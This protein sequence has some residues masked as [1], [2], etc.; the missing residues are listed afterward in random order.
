M[1]SG[2]RGIFLLLFAL[3][4]FSGLIYESIWT[5]YLKLFLGHAAYAQTLVLAIF[6]GGMAIGSALS[7]RY[8]VRWKNLLLCYAI[9]EGLIGVCALAFHIA[10]NLTTDFSY[11]TVIP[12]LNNPAVVNAFK[13]TIS[14][15]MILPQSVLLG[16]T[17]P[18]MSAGI[19]R[20]FPDKPGSTVAMLYFTNSIGAATGVLASG[21]VLIRLVGLPGTIGIAGLINIALAVTVWQLLKKPVTPGKTAGSKAVS[22]AEGTGHKRS[23]A[24]TKTQPAV[25]GCSGNEQTPELRVAIEKSSP[26]AGQIH[27]SPSWYRFFLLASLV[28][29][30]ASFIYEIGWIRMLSLVLGSSTHS[31]ELM[32]SAFILGL[33][34]GGLWI[35]WRIER[36]ASPVRYLAHVQ[37]CMGLLALLT[38]PLYGTTFT[39]MQWLV[40]TLDKTDTGYALFNLSSS[41]IAMTVML[42]ATFCAGMTLP[43]ITFI[44]IRGGHGERSIGAVYA[45]NTIGAII[46]VFFAIHLGMPF[47]GLNN[48]I[49]CGAGLDIA[50]G[51][52]L[53]WFAL[54]EYGS[55]RIPVIATVTGC[56]AVAATLLFVRLDPYKMGSG[57]YRAGEIMTPATAEVLYHMDGKTATVTCFRGNDA[58]V[59]IRTNGKS[60]AAIMTAQGSEASP[61][62]ST[63]TLLAVIPMSLNPRATTA[64]AIGLGSGLTSHTLLSNP[65]LQQVD[66]VEIEKGMIEGANNFRPRVESVFSDP[67]SK[68]RIDDAKTFFSTYNK[69]YDLIVSEPSNPWVSGVAGLFSAEFY[70]LIRRHMNDD[71]LFV[72]WIQLYEINVDLVVSVLKSISANFSDYA[73]Y[74]SNNSDIMVIARKNGRLPAPD[75]GVLKIPAIADALKRIHVE[76]VEDIEIRRIGNKHSFSRLL[77]TFPI[78][79]NSDYYPVLDQ[80]AAR[81]RFLGS[82]AQELL[83]FNYTMGMLESTEQQKATT[84]ITPSP[85]LTISQQTF[86]AMGLRD[87][88]LHG[89]SNGRFVPVDLQRKAELLK[90]MCAGNATG[91]GNERLELQFSLSNAMSLFLTSSEME[92]VW[93]T[94]ATGPCNAPASPQEREWFKLFKAVGTRD[95]GAMLEGAKSLLADGSYR[96]SDLKKYLLWVGMLGALSQGKR[97]DSSRLWSEY[98]V[99]LF[100]GSN[101]PTLM[102]RM[103]AAESR[104]PDP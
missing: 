66:T 21:F 33:A 69:K 17:F 95:A 73:V 74:A 85:D 20:L 65:R 51:V 27:A 12:H 101:E 53:C 77:E 103:L 22:T 54:G 57:V 92:A 63:M 37:V 19:L 81:A 50:L 38:L 24:K 60:D 41:A 100:N 45:A 15:L 29:G 46:G 97:E 96:S 58:S 7:S 70:R 99:K 84:N 55:R 94:L 31:F 49:A 2:L 59:S 4:G 32:L 71:A 9:T 14:A 61:D 78:Q 89:S 93:K 79:E 42:P 40:K 23:K 10:F 36:V 1:K 82:T 64:A 47:L 91:S 3:S 88:F 102:F 62:E 26:G 56:C 28:T 5:D 76:G 104:P 80:G 86:S 35:H 6:M 16:M 83:N 87:Y 11:T 34:L 52:G 48:L 44:L 43:L 18:L 67:R 90:Q 98:G 13:W 8:S 25:E 30:A 72:Q 68:I 75:A 39:F